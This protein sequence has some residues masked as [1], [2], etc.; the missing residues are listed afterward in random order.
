[1]ERQGKYEAAAKKFRRVTEIKPDFDLVFIKLAW[2]LNC[3]ER[4]DE[5]EKMIQKAL[6]INPTNSDHWTSYA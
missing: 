6:D 2:S 5:A 1:M 3:L 4:E